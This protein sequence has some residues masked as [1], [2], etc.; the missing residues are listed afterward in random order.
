MDHG[1]LYFFDLTKTTWYIHVFKKVK[2]QTPAARSP[3][4]TPL[5]DCVR[6]KYKHVK[7]LTSMN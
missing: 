7:I 4:S 5:S 6:V 3:R 2:L 1:I